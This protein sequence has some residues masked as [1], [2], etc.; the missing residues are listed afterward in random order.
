MRVPLLKD[1]TAGFAA[2][3]AVLLVVILAI[4]GGVGT[5][6]AQQKHTA[7]STLA[8]SNSKSVPARTPVTPGSATSIDQLTQK[9]AQ[10]EANIDKSADS[11]A[12][13]NAISSNSA[14]TNVGG[15]YDETNL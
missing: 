14:V 2:V 1:N 12:Q 15:S 4:I 13:Q 3:E 5:Y 9:D 8:S 10:A 7:D 6:V 11:Q